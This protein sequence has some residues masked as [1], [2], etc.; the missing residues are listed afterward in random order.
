MKKLHV[1]YSPESN[2]FEVEQFEFPNQKNK[3]EKNFIIEI[4]A[5]D[6]NGS[7]NDALTDYCQKLNIKTRPW[8]GR[9][10][11]TEKDKPKFI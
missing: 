9:L 11:N 4:T 10:P 6:K 5:N 3:N 1:L 2:K 7:V 8:K